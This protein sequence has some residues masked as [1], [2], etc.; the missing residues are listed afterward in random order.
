VA[1]LSYMGNDE[2]LLEYENVL[3]GIFAVKFNTSNGKV[4]SVD[5]KANEFVEYDPYTFTKK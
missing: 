4:N 5:I 1:N 3:Y 2:W